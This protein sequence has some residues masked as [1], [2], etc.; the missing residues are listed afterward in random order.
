[1]IMTYGASFLFLDALR[2]QG[3]EEGK[4]DD[5]GGDLLSCSIILCR[6]D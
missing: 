6:S 4:Q 2:T 1:M 5:P 3:E